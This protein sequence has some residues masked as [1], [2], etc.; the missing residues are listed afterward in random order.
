MRK[1]AQQ[2]REVLRKETLSKTNICL[3]DKDNKMFSMEQSA[4]YL[5]N[6]ER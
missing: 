3:F 2:F 6:A 1:A 4:K 5:K